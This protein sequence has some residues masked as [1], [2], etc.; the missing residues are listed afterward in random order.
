MLIIAPF[1][2][3]RKILNDLRAVC[4]KDVWTVFVYENAGVIVAVKRIARDMTPLVDD[5][6]TLAHSIGETL[7]KHRASETSTD[8]KIVVLVVTPGTDFDRD[9]RQ[10]ERCNCLALNFSRTHAN[11]LD[12]LPHRIPGLIP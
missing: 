4:M 7:G 6:H 5:E 8:D 3:L 2:E 12:L 10:A 11:P 1:S 9:G